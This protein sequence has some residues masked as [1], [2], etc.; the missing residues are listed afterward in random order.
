MW[1]GP[2]L[3]IA[4]LII[5]LAPMDQIRR[6]K[7]VVVIEVLLIAAMVWLCYKTG[8]VSFG[9]VLL[10]A[11]MLSTLISTV[12]RLYQPEVPMPAKQYAARALLTLGAI[13]VTMILM[14][15]F[16]G[17][18]FSDFAKTIYVVPVLIPAVIFF[19]GWLRR[20]NKPV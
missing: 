8:Q 3:V 18:P 17:R 9:R 20:R 15:I 10:V 5:L 12:R 14:V 2:G 1:V 4:V 7:A 6:L 16:S 11:I 19:V 13:V